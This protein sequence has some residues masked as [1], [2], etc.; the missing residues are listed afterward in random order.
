MDTLP[1]EATT[2]AV[3]VG[4]NDGTITTSHS[5]GDVVSTGTYTGGLIGWNHGI[6]IAS[7]SKGSIEFTGLVS[8]G[9]SYT[10]GFSGR[11]DGGTIV[12][13]YAASDVVGGITG[14]WWAITL[15]AV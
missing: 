4:W 11:N 8:G 1:P 15:A 12:C 13:C 7:Y 2:Q 10:G 6:V 9:I 14:D 5:S 3:L